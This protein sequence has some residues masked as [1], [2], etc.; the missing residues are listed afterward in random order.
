MEMKRL[1]WPSEALLSGDIRSAQSKI[2]VQNKLDGAREFIDHISTYEQQDYLPNDILVKS[3]RTSMAFGL[4]SRA[5]I[6]DPSVAAIAHSL[7]PSISGANGVPK[8]PLKQLLYQ[9]VPRALVDRPK[10]GFNLPIAEWLR[11]E[12][13]EWCCEVLFAESRGGWLF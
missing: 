11:T 3:D 8:W 7:D 4:E 10:M 5:P 1:V 12:M 2:G 6:L 9:K 13:R